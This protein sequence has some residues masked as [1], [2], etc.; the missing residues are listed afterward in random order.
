M[1]YK[2]VTITKDY[3]G[4]Y[5]AMVAMYDLKSGQYYFQPAQADSLSGIKKL[6]NHFKAFSD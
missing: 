2:N 5:T 3:R 1:S 4:F 6:I